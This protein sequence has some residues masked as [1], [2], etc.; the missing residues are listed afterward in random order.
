MSSSVGRVT[1]RRSSSM[2]R[3]AAHSS[4][5]ARSRVGVAVR[6]CTVVALDDRARGQRQRLVEARQPEADDGVA[7]APELVRRALGDDVAAREHD[8]AVGE[9]LRLLHVVRGEQ[10]RL[11]ERAQVGDRLPRLAPRGRV[12]AGRR[13][14]EED[15]VGVADQAQR[16]V[17]PPPLAAG[18]VGGAVLGA[19]LRARPARAARAPAA[20]SRRRPRRAR[21]PRRP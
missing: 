11:P 15:Q 6:N 14:V 1:V 8:D 21:S 10:D 16:E 7:L 20:G 18:E 12:E 4:T 2:P 17:E 19:V 9:P 13:L 5:G 3:C